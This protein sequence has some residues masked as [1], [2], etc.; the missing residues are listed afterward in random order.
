MLKREHDSLLDVVSAGN[1][2][3]EFTHGAT[4]D[5]Y[6]NNLLLRSAV[7]RQFMIVG[8]AFVRLR[9]I[10]DTWLERIP[11]ARRII[12]FRNVLVHGYDSIADDRV[13]MP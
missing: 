2:I 4:L 3:L 8:E 1:A 12:G 5:Q 9:D 11:N 7:E 13:W 6:S 10:D